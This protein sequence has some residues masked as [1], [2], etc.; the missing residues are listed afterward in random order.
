MADTWEFKFSGVPLP[1]TVD[2][3][4]FVAEVR[5]GLQDILDRHEQMLGQET[6]P[7]TGSVLKKYSKLYESLIM[8][9]KVKG[10]NGVRKVSTRVNFTITGAFRR[11]R[12]VVNEPTGGKL[13]FQGQHWSGYS[14]QG[15]AEKLEKKWKDFTALGVRDVDILD[16]RLTKELERQLEKIDK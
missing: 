2:T 15:L 7:A 10:P 8:A 13:R 4:A 1:E 3:Q 12:Q 6:N 9:G 16:K 14:G 11:S 5:R